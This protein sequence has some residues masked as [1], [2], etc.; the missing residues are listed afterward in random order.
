MTQENQ[1][2]PNISIRNLSEGGTPLR[3][4]YGILDSYSPERNQYNRIRVG[5]NYKDL[6]VLESTE[7]YAFPIC[8]IPISF[9]N[10]AKSKWG[11]FAKSIADCVPEDAD[12]EYLIGKRIGMVFTDG[13]DGRPEPHM[14]YDGQT[15]EDVPTAVW[16]VFEVDGT[17]RGFGK[18]TPMDVALS[19]LD[20]KNQNEFNTLAL[21]DPQIRQDTDLL[22]AITSKEFVATMITA[23]KVTVDAQGVHH[24]V[25]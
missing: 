11:F 24:V 9:S 10:R 23:G 16:E 25:K 22:K 4:F 14:L 2:M 19:I 17:V 7:P 6:E 1:D 5:L 3:R 15:E 13:K 20:G 21:A 8:T 18:K 12:I